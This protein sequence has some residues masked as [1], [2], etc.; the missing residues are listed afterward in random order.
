MFMQKSDVHN[1][2][3][4]LERIN[5]V[6]IAKGIAISYI[7][8]IPLFFIFAYILTYTSFPEK[9]ISTSVLITTIISILLAGSTTTKGVRSKGWLNGAFVGFVYM[10]IL[11]LFSSIAFSDFTVNEHIISMTFIGIFTGAIGGIMG[12]NAKEM[13]KKKYKQV[14]KVKKISASL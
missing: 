13:Y 9:Y 14:K 4:L 12:I 8:T 11:Y 10:V 6:S 7:I 1:K 2:T 5:L 3:S